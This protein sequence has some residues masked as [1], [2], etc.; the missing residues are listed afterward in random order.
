MLSAQIG[1]VQNPKA[2][3]F[4]LVVYI[5]K[6]RNVTSTFDSF[7]N[8]TLVSS[9]DT[10]HSA[11]KN[12]SALRCKSAKTTCILVIDIV[13]LI[14]TEGANLL[15]LTSLKVLIHLKVLLYS[16]IRMEVLRRHQQALQNQS[17]KKR[18]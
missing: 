9:A 2:F 14:S 18:S 1:A 13:Y 12:F 17:L 5:G 10:C 3:S 8:L 7:C 6:K 16:K 11:G 4:V 15:T